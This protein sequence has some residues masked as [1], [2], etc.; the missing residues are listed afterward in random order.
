MG[1]LMTIQGGTNLTPLDEALLVHVQ[2][3]Y[4]CMVH[5]YGVNIVIVFE[6]DTLVTIS[7]VHIME[8]S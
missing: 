2:R 6:V 7:G 8:V 5:S 1:H 3:M 4:L